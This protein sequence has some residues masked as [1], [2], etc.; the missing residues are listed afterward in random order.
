MKTK[1]II[2]D[3]NKEQYHELYMEAVV[4]GLSVYWSESQFIG[5]GRLW[6]NDKKELHS[7]HSGRSSY[8]QLS[9]DNFKNNLKLNNCET[10]KE[11]DLIVGRYYISISSTANGRQKG[12]KIKITSI[13]GSHLNYECKK[14][15]LEC[16]KVNFIKNCKP[17]K[18]DISFDREIKKGEYVTCLYHFDNDIRTNGS[19]HKVLEEPLEG[20]ICYEDIIG[21]KTVSKKISE[22]RLSTESE[23][24][25]SRYA[26]EYN[27][28]FINGNNA[29]NSNSNEVQSKSKANSRANR[30]QAISARR[31]S[32]KIASSKRLT[33]NKVS[34]VTR[35]SKVRTAKISTS[36][37][38]ISRS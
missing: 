21:N 37:V 14:G 35:R 38:F 36:P 1:V 2:N 28:P 7:G 27:N 33:G 23:I 17:F 24:L 26:K 9:F 10:M 13:K 20:K 5:S 29:T 32:S 3:L 6:I 30:G 16:R 8:K 31:K 11:S 18:E 34:V 12:E 4:S 22:F 25:A 19:V 15:N